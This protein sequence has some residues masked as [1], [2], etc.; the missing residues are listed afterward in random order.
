[1]VKGLKMALYDSLDKAP[2]GVQESLKSSHFT[3]KG[4]IQVF[5]AENPEEFY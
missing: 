4:A 2:S 3:P 5:E 1:M